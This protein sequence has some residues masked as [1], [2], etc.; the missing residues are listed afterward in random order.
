[1]YQDLQGKVAVVTGSSSGI[2]A[3]VVSRLVNEGMNVVINYHSNEQEAQKLADSLNKLGKGQAII[4]GGDISDEEVAHNF[5]YQAITHFGKLDLLINNAGI[6]NQT[7]SHAINLEEWHKII[8]V[9]L[10]S[11]FLT[12]RSALRY[13]VENKMPGNIINMSS[14][15]EIIPWPTFASYAASKGGVRMLTQSL[16]LEYASQGIRI[17]A[18]GPGAINTPIN[19]EKME[20]DALRKEL[21]A[22]IPMKYAAEPEAVANVAAWLA[23]EQST[24]ITGQTIFIDGGMTL[25]PSFQG[26]KG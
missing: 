25:Y 23:S 19:K 12:A 14:V 17:N 6:E 3:A 8:D 24:Y 9:N 11:Y 21:E 1:M 10:T 22:M 18:I 15:H 26:G 13:F 20:D 2:G 4:F 5:I 16:A 7:P